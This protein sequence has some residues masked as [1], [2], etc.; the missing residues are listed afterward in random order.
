LLGVRVSGLTRAQDVPASSAFS[1]A[2]PDGD[3]TPSLF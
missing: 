1:A 3:A 2:E